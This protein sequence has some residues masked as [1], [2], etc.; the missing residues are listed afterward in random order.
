MGTVLLLSMAAFAVGFWVAT[1][2]DDQIENGPNP[3]KSY[4]E[5]M[6]RI[7]NYNRSV[8]ADEVETLEVQYRKKNGL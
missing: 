2:K 6:Q 5:M 1:T 3:A 8:G 7:N 4:E